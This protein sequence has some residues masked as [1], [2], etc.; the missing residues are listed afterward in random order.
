MLDMGCGLGSLTKNIAPHVSKVYA[1]DLAYSRLVF[2]RK[3]FEKCNPNDDITVVAGGD[4]VFLPFADKSIDCV[5][6][7]GVLEWAAPV[8]SAWLNRGTKTARALRMVWSYFGKRHPRRMQADLLKEIRRVLTEEGQLFIAIENRLN[9]QYLKGRPDHHSF[10]LY[11]SLLPRFMANLYSIW[12]SRRP[13]RTYTYSISGYARLLEEAGFQRCEF[14]GLFPA[15]TE[16]QEVI[17]VQATVERWAPRLPAQVKKRIQR[18]RYFV[19]A[20]GI[21]ANTSPRWR[22]RLLDGIL[23][24]I[25]LGLS[26]RFGS[27]PLEITQYSVTRKD[28]GV[29]IGSIGSQ[30]I[31][32]KLPFN[33]ASVGGEERNA[34]MLQRLRSES[35]RDLAYCP[36]PLFQGCHQDI[37]FYVEERADGEPL[38]N[39]VRKRGRGAFLGIVERVLCDLNASS[40]VHEK[41]ALTGA[42]YESR[43]SE[44]LELLFRVIKE[45][46]TRELLTSYFEDHFYGMNIRVGLSHGDFGLNNIFVDQNDVTGLIDWEWGSFAGIPLLD[47]FKFLISVHQCFWPGYGLP[48]SLLQLASGEW[49]VAEE[50]EF[51]L[52]V[53]DRNQVDLSNHRALV[54]LYWLHAVSC[55]LQYKMIFDEERM[56]V[57][58]DSVIK[59]LFL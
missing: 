38:R 23:S 36:Q 48:E 50:R 33:S 26:D 41:T 55:H 8:D 7:S 39:L 53:Y 44:P 58:I 37:S 27:A 47:A 57:E 12:K 3:R 35:V 32:I 21:I 28:K 59:Q 45:R 31:V 5:I 22:A 10:L 1:M 51:L 29:M 19:P 6:L 18:S 16:L 42:I 52:R 56:K 13:Y 15:Y 11:G 40:A 46:A 24:V 49:S 4:G 30:P 14:F 54:Y 17:P 25:H 9:Y 2:A 20:Y 34:E 43:V